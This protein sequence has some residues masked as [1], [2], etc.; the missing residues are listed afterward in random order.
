MKTYVLHSVLPPTLQVEFVQSSD[1]A[2]LHGL[3]TLILGIIQVEGGEI[4]HS[5]CAEGQK[6]QPG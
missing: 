2:A 5:E 1:N 3:H 6:V 4:E